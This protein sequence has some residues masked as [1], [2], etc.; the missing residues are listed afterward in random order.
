MADQVIKKYK[1]ERA[2]QRGINKMER[3]GYEV[4]Q[5]GTRKA[6]WNWKTGVFTRKQ[7]HTIVFKKKASSVAPEP[8]TATP[9]PASAGP[10][11]GSNTTARVVGGVMTAGLSEA[12]LFAV[13]QSKKAAA[14]RT[15]AA[16]GTVDF[17][18]ARGKAEARFQTAEG[19]TAPDQQATG[20]PA[21]PPA[22]AEPTQ[23]AA[24]TPPAAAEPTQTAAAT[25]PAA[26][27]PTQP[28]PP[29]TEAIGAA[30]SVADELAKLAAL[31]ESGVL[32]DEEF[33]TQK[34]KLLA[35]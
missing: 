5:A 27:E 34:A 25:P 28:P 31:C 16:F 9:E 2:A 13:R 29:P 21:T 12:A 33:A 26:G 19:D 20:G 15:Q 1:G 11:P 30:G 32:T 23:P 18:A 4:D 22:T 10:E 6:M 8:G 14:K 17:D 35:G 24:A 3:Q 7:I